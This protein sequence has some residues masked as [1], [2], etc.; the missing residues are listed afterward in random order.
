MPR[1]VEGMSLLGVSF[2]IDASVRDNLRNRLAILSNA[3]KAAK[4]RPQHTLHA[5]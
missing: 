1:D 2:E 3:I 5:A 4:E